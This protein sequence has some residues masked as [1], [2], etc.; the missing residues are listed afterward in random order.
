MSDLDRRPAPS[1]IRARR[2][3][4]PQHRSPDAP[5]F[6]LVELLVAAILTALLSA[7]GLAVLSG[8]VN[9]WSRSAGRLRAAAQAHLALD[10]IAQ[11]LE[12][13]IFRA[14][15]NV[16]LAVTVLP[17]TGLSGQWKP[18]TVPTQGKPGNTHARTLSLT[19]PSLEKARFGVA[20]VWLRFFTT[21]L[22]TGVSTSNLSAPV[23]VG[24]QIIRQHVTS[25]PASEQRYLLFR[26]EV[27]RSRTAGGA[28]GVFEAGYDLDPLAAPATPY[29]AAGGTS[30]DPGNLL[31]PPLGA[32]LADNVIDFGVRL[33]RKES[34]GMRL[35]FPARP[36][37]V[38]AAPASGELSSAA[39][40]SAETQHLACST[41]P[42][43]DDH[44]RHAFPDV[45][46]VMLR[47]LTDEGARLVAACEAG[48]LQPP[49]GVA[50]ADYWWSLAEAR[51]QVFTRRIT[52]AGRPF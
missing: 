15:G 30:G 8:V 32:V 16:W 42:A 25:S 27:R 36:A 24:Y 13:A 17:D 11:D 52:I 46:E 50:A 3:R 1:K 9:H 41:A 47:V 19:V 38:G 20:G 28:P 22:D 39:P 45:A 40:P 26:A 37:T 51:S 12:S 10:Q 14:D 23:A 48:H 44:Y 35:I 34:G 33:Y 18:A 6:T 7:I 5:G 21:K 2:L 29:M 49:A 43:A 4:G 31:R